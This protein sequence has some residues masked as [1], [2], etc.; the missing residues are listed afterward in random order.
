MCSAGACFHGCLAEGTPYA[1]GDANPANA[2]QVC[3]PSANPTGFVAAADSTPCASDQNP[4]TDDVCASGACTHPASAQ[5]TTCGGTG[6]CDG[7][8]SCSAGCD[9]GTN[10]YAAGA[11]NPANPCQVCDPASSGTAWSQAA[12]GTGCGTGQVCDATGACRSGCY[13]GGT[14]YAGSDPNPA[15]AC[16]TCDP[17]TSTSAFTPVSNGTTC[18]AITGCGAWGSCGPAA[19]A[20]P[21]DT[22]GTQSRTCTQPACQAGSC[23]S[24]SVT[25]KQSCTLN[26]DGTACASDS[27]PCTADLC[28]SGA[29]THPALATGAVCG[30]GKACD[31]TGACVTGCTIGGQTWLPGTQNPANGCEVCDPSA[32]TT[33]WSPGNAGATCASG[34]CGAWSACTFS[35]TCSNTGTRTRTCTAYTCGGGTCGGTS[36]TQTDTTSC[37][38]NTDGTACGIGCNASCS[39]GLCT[40]HCPVKTVCMCGGQCLTPG[41]NCP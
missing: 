35:G 30:T 1:P 24:G 26:T 17:A 37:T 3:D 25:Q 22:T 12:P 40:D 6:Q 33:G 32:S 19:G 36:S 38:R 31:A 20:G 39:S 11:V 18:G 13:V 5:G 41:S 21:C 23:T 15:N 29:C 10:H 28:A 4:C 16:Q 34:S 14:L 7:S 27:D 9:I 8:G 2:C